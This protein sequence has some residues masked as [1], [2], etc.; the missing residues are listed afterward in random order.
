MNIHE[1]N[2]NEQ[3]FDTIHQ[4]QYSQLGDP[5]SLSHRS[6]KFKNENHDSHIINNNLLERNGSSSEL[7]ETHHV[8]WLDVLRLACTYSVCSMHINRLFD[9]HP[10]EL[11]LGHSYQAEMVSRMHLQM[12]IPL[13][14]SVAGF[15]FAGILSYTYKKIM[16]NNQNPQNNL[17]NQNKDLIQNKNSII[18]SLFNGKTIFYSLFKYLFLKRFTKLIGLGI[19]GLFTVVPIERFIY[20]KMTGFENGFIHWIIQRKSTDWLNPGVVWFVFVLFFLWLINFRMACMWVYQ[21]EA[22]EFSKKEIILQLHQE[23]DNDFRENKTSPLDLIKD[24][25]RLEET[26]IHL[27]QLPSSK[28]NNIWSSFQKIIDWRGLIIQEILLFIVF[29]LLQ[30]SDWLILGHSSFISKYIHYIPNME[31]RSNY[32]YLDSHETEFAMKFFKNIFFMYHIMWI[33]SFIRGYLKLLK[34]STHLLSIITQGL[35]ILNQI[36]LFYSFDPSPSSANPYSLTLHTLI[37]IL[38]YLNAYFI[39]GFQLNLHECIIYKENED[40]EKS[41]V[42]GMSD[43][44]SNLQIIITILLLPVTPLIIPEM[45]SGFISLDRTY[46]N[47]VS[48]IFYELG[49]F[50]WMYWFYA[51]FSSQCKRLPPKYEK[52]WKFLYGGQLYLYLLHSM[53]MYFVVH[54]MEKW[55]F[56]FSMMWKYVFLQISIPTLCYLSYCLVELLKIIF[57]RS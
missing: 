35:L 56:H 48:R 31:I 37:H 50:F 40:Q 2:K 43:S 38:I 52:Y 44:L 54:F 30:F 22:F 29:I 41:S 28:I 6:K 57:K 8:F 51:F 20:A 47:P 55:L 42:N 17:Y 19:L 9:L 39:F 1:I 24:Q 36:Y 46:L 15:T 18:S 33:A 25:N 16:Q 53:W 12:G 45:G 26:V 10:T 3:E 21:S 7:K 49:C 34:R 14:M 13:F 27:N 11:S 5:I 32:S 4:T 23:N